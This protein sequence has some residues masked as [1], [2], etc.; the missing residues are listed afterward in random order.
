MTKFTSL[1]KELSNNSEVSSC[2]LLAQFKNSDEVSPFALAG[3]GDT[4]DPLELS[5]LDGTVDD[6]PELISHVPP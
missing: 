3:C 1:S 5:T 2:L 4:S 6:N